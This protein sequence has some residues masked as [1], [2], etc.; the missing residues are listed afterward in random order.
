M[1]FFSNLAAEAYDRAYSDRQIVQ[2]LASYFVPQRRLLIPVFIVVVLQTILGVLDPF[3]VARGLDAMK[4]NPSAQV[5]WLIVGAVLASAVLTWFGNLMRRRL[6]ARLIANLIQHIRSDAFAAA[7]QHDMSFFDRYQS[8]KIISRITNDT[9]EL[10]QVV[11]LLSDFAAQFT[12]LI[13][14]V[15]YLLTVSWQLTLVLLLM[16]PFLVLFGA[17]LRKIARTVTR[18]GFQAIG[19]VN[20]SIQE[21]VAGM[22]VAKNFR[23]EAAIYE[24]F[25][26]VNNRSYQVN[27]RRGFVLSNVF[28]VVN[29]LAGLG[30]ALLVYTGGLSVYNGAISIGAWYLFI[31]S[32]DR[33]WFPMTNL[34]SFWS[35][36]QGGLSACE[37]IFALID[38]EPSVRQLVKQTTLASE[39]A[40]A[41]PVILKGEIEFKHVD[42]RYNEQQKVLDDFSLRIRPGESVAFVGHTGAGKSSVIKLITRFYEFQ[43]GQILMDGRDIRNFDLRYYRRQLGLVSQSPFLFAGT[44]L[45]NIRYA[46]PNLT[47]AEVETVAR[48]IGNGEWLETLSHGLNTE[49]GER[50]NRLS[51]GQRQLVAL[52]RVLAQKPPIF[53]LDE[54]TASVD[55]FTESQ[56]QTALNLILSESTS[57]LI[58][59]RLSTVKSADRIIALDHGHIIE[60]GNH[61][62]LLARNGYYAELYQT[63]FR[64]QSLD[65]KIVSAAA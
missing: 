36:I 19:E 11:L 20:A 49:V 39:D 41:N 54:A 61:E 31:I 9:Q 57:I 55:P 18:S 22:R 27:L 60:E 17:A 28:P 65:Y 45:D 47:D 30:S 44:V 53:I 21:A 62:Q 64:H 34:T 38:A 26:G 16:S 51:M 23:Q 43:D 59:H 14:L 48:R 63:Y 24:N 2:R 42:F 8:G 52:S 5:I 6:T 33:F 15:I 35:Q 4:T 12:I 13:A 7:V 50:G 3:I 32:L 25:K 1:A 10:S 58:A 29:T 37:R 40:S 56:I 46:T